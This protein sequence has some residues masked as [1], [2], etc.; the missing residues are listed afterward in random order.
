MAYFPSSG[1]Q[2]AVLPYSRAWL[3]LDAELDR[4]TL[5]WQE[6]ETRLARDFHWLGLPE[7]DR[8]A[9]P[10][11]RTLYALDD[12]ITTLM[13]RRWALLETLEALPAT[14]LHDVAGKLAVAV[15]LLQDQ[16][17]IESDLLAEAVRELAGRAC[18]ACGV[19]L[20]PP[21]LLA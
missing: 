13:E 19:R 10:E 18:P 12:Q 16:G 5:A 11:A 3:A 2:D 17:A 20:I 21:D 9:H 8:R 4:L 15:R 6:E 1:G 14:D 7:A